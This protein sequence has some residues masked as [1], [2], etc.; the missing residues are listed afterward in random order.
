MVSIDVRHGVERA[1]EFALSRNVAP[2]LIAAFAAL[3]AVTAPPAALL[4]LAILGARAL[5]TSQTL[6]FYPI[7]AIG[8]VFAALVVFA[9]MG[10]AGAIGVLFAWRLIADASWSVGEARR[11]AVAA[12]RPEQSRFKALAHAW[13]TP[14]LGLAMVA[15]SSPHLVMG[16]PLD[17]PH[18]PVFAPIAVAVVAGILVFDW[19]LRCAADWRLGELAPAPAAH[20]LAHH[21]VFVCAYVAGMD[22]SAG[23]AALIAWRLAHAAPLNATFPRTRLLLPSR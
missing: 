2:C 13:A 10:L 14:L 11:L 16:L 5:S 1:G 20:L 17:L 22:L 21:V 19:A 3:L 8:P 18:V 6:R 7:A 23:V 15:W 12:G 4:L 9:V